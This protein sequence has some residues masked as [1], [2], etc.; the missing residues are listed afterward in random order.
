M[1]S[2][3][4]LPLQLL[5]SVNNVLFLFI[6]FVIGIGREIEHVGAN[7]S[8]DVFQVSVRITCTIKLN[9]EENSAQLPGKEQ[10]L[11]SFFDKQKIYFEAEGINPDRNTWG[12]YFLKKIR[13][14]RD[15]LKDIKLY[16]YD[17]CVQYAHVISTYSFSYFL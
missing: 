5:S 6:F 4:Q 9:I 11:C 8:T 15:I 2:T 14:R 3:L 16:T 17:I 13:L 7:E 12:E 10:T 1:K